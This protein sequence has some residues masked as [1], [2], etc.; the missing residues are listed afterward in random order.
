MDDW[1]SWDD[2]DDSLRIGE[3][4]WIRTWRNKLIKGSHGIINQRVRKIRIR[5]I[6]I[7]R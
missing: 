4:N 1:T 6:E 5:F 2:D 3:E 7:V